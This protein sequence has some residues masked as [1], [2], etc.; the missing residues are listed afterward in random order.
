MVLKGMRLI[1]R[2][3]SRW[4]S[5]GIAA[6]ASAYKITGFKKLSV[7]SLSSIQIY[8]RKI[9]PDQRGKQETI[10]GR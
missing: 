4:I 8:R 10:G 5:S 6:A 9:I 7:N 1:L 2:R 3:L